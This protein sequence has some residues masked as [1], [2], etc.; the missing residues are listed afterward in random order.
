MGE[1]HELTKEQ[2]LKYFRE[3]LDKDI[4]FSMIDLYGDYLWNPKSTCQLNKSDLLMLQI[5]RLLR[6][7]K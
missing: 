1:K 3:L 4:V 6:K 2:I 7:R 5:I